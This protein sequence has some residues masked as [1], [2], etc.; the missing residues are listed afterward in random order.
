MFVV[1]IT[2]DIF[3]EGYFVLGL[4]LTPDMSADESHISVQC[5]GSCAL[6]YG[7]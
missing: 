2:M 6:E 1:M 5:L 7:V 4:G 3:L